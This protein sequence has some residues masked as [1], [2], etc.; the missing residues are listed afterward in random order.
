[1]TTEKSLSTGL[2]EVGKALPGLQSVMKELEEASI[3]TAALQARQANVLKG[4]TAWLEE[5][6]K[7]MAA[8]EAR[9]A[10][11]EIRVDE[12]IEKLVSAIGEIGRRRK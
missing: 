10:E 3:V 12:R 9:L 5:H 6:E 11:T 2:A 7:R 4:N 8:L 1:M